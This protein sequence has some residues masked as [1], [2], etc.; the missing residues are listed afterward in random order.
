L[1]IS[2]VMLTMTF[3]IMP[4]NGYQSEPIYTLLWIPMDT[5]DHRTRTLRDGRGL[6]RSLRGLPEIQGAD[7]LS[8]PVFDYR[9]S[10]GE[11]IAKTESNVRRIDQHEYR[12][13]SQSGKG[14]YTVLQTELGWQ[15]SCPDFAYRGVKCKHAFAVELSLQ[16]RRRIENAR[17]VVPLDYQSCLCCGSDRIK[18]EAYSTTR[19]E[20]FRG[21]SAF[22]VGRGSP[23][24]SASSA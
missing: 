11:A 2:S 13:R 8:A 12:V 5:N 14:E 22:R 16:I 6:R 24:T 17:R 20:T 1:T 19:A 9:A 15:C 21:S 7:G 4:T 10:R 18:R 23:T 3:S